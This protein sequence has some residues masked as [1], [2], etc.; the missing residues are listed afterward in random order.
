MRIPVLVA[1]CAVLCGGAFLAVS[2]ASASAPE[3]DPDFSGFVVEQMG[4]VRTY[5]E[6]D[7]WAAIPGPQSFTLERRGLQIVY[8]GNFIAEEVSAAKR[9]DPPPSAL[10]TGTSFTVVAFGKTRNFP[11]VEGWSG[12]LNASGLFVRRRG[13]TVWFYGTARVEAPQ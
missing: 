1:A 7:G 4:E 6:E 5:P 11:S 13:H 10:K 9:S 2:A 12:S 8:Y 3:N